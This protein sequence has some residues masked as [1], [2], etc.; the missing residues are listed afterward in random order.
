MMR[1]ASCLL[2]VQFLSFPL[3]LCIFCL[4]L[5]KALDRSFLSAWDHYLVFS[6]STE[7]GYE[8]SKNCSPEGKAF[9]MKTKFISL[10]VMSDSFLKNFK[11]SLTSSDRTDPSAW[12]P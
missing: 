2:Q 10:R 1:Q 11:A 5:L 12:V 6:P 9:P 4:S 8:H 7:A 3:D